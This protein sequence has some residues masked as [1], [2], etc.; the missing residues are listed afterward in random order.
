MSQFEQSARV[1]RVIVAPGVA[2]SGGVARALV[3]HGNLYPSLAELRVRYAEQSAGQSL[4]AMLRGPA[5]HGR[6]GALT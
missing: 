6:M 5:H 3:S 1:P 4:V 2:V